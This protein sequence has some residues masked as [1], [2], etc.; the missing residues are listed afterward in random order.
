MFE[1]LS[2][3]HSYTPPDLL[4]QPDV[5]LVDSESVAQSEKVEFTINELANEFSLTHRALR[6]YESRRLLS[7]RRDG[8]R[9]FFSRADRDRLALVLKGKKLGFTLTEISEMIEAHGRATE[10]GLKLTSEKCVEQIAHFERQIAD[11]EEALRE[12]RRIHVVFSGQL[13]S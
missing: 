13:K 10:H 11:A 8:R 5:F 7:P 2:S 12:L 9:R 6:F 3:V 1:R 4:A